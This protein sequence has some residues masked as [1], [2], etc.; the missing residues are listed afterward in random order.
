MPG[1]VSV[2]DAAALLG[3]ELESEAATVGGLVIAELGR[4]PVPGDTAEIAG[5]QWRVDRIAG[6][7]VESVLVSRLTSVSREEGA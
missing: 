1:G 7:A 3:A 4:L 6:R 2:T 5:C